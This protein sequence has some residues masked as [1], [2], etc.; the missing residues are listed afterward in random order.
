[1]DV[2]FWI[3]PAGSGK[4]HRCLVALRRAEREGRG[5]LF[6][7]PE[8]FTYSADR[9]LLDP[10]VGGPERL[11]E[12]AQAAAPA[13]HPETRSPAPAPEGTRHV[14][15]LSFRRL[16]YLV[17]DETGRFPPTVDPGG[18]EMLLRLAL[19]SVEE[20]GPLAPL[21][22]KEGF[23]RELA[24]LVRDLRLHAPDPDTPLGEKLASL[25]DPKLR[26]LGR[27]LR[28]YDTLLREAGLHDPEE[29]LD[30]A[31]RRLEASGA[32]VAGREVYVDGFMSFTAPEMRILRILARCARRLVVT[33]CL[34]PEDLRVFREA[35]DAAR[36][37]GIPCPEAGF[38][39]TVYRHLRRP[40]FS[41]TARTL[42]LLERAFSR[43]GLRVRIE[44]LRERPRFAHGVLARVEREVGSADA[45]TPP[46]KKADGA[47]ELAAAVNPAEEVLLW[48]RRIDRWV[49]LGQGMRYRDVAILLR[50]P[51]AYAGL[52]HEIFPRYDIPF[53]LDLPTDLSSHPLPATLLAILGIL[54]HAWSRDS[55]MAFLRSPLLGLSSFEADLVENVSL[56]YGIEY[57]RWYAAPWAACIVPPQRRTQE[58]EDEEEDGRLERELRI[59]EAQVAL[60]NRVRESYLLP[61]RR[62][63]ETWRDG[64]L[65]FREAVRGL[66]E[67]AEELNLREEAL[68]LAAAAEAAS[69]GSDPRSP[70]PAATFPDLRTTRQVFNHL[71]AFLEEGVRLMGNVPVT[72]LLFSR[73]LRDG[74]GALRLGRTPQSLDAVTIGDFQRSRINEARAVIV[75]GLTAEAV[76]RLVPDRPLLAREEEERM[77]RVGLLAGPS[78]QARQDEEAYLAYIALTRARERLLLTYPGN[79]TT[80]DALHVS[81]YLALL[82]ARLGRTIPVP[83][84]VETD[85]PQTPVELAASVGS[86]L[87]QQME[88]EEAGLAPVS[89]V[90]APGAAEGP[91]AEEGSGSEAGLMPES[92]TPAGPGTKEKTSPATLDHTAAMAL[93]AVGRRE[94]FPPP[95]AETLRRVLVHTRPWR[96]SPEVVRIVYPDGEVRTSATGLE[97]FSECPYRRFA[98]RVLRL[99]PRPDT[100]IRPRET[101]SAMH[102]A[103]ELFFRRR[104]LP[105]AEEID[106]LLEEIFSELLREP[107]FQ[108]FDLDAPSRYEWESLRRRLAHFLQAEARRLAEAAFRPERMESRFG[109]PGPEA[110]EALVVELGRRGRIVLRGAV[111]RVDAH[112]GNAVVV[113]Y[114]RTPRHGTVR[115]LLEEGRFLQ[116]G[117]YML[118]IRDLLGLQ[119]VGGFYVAVMPKPPQESESR[120][121]ENPLNIRFQGIILREELERYDPRGAFVTKGSSLVSEEELRRLLE[122]TRGYVRLFG[123]A[124]LEGQIRAVP[125]AGES[126]E[127]R[128]C[129][130]CDFRDLCRFDPLK[131]PVLTAHPD[132]L[133][134]EAGAGGTDP[135]EPGATADPA[136][137]NEPQPSAGRPDPEETPDA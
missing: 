10:A 85:P 92:D 45:A 27:I 53:F 13:S 22:G 59:Q 83:R 104:T 127:P 106:P 118:A 134:R 112:G 29:R 95:V 65:P 57:Q 46:A 93:Y 38:P 39:P 56:E 119:P 1:M 14:R 78:P 105:K 126:G 66:L 70:G 103:L 110:A 19:E 43:E 51:Q 5:A 23:V 111:D 72:P 122:R 60:G 86:R 117:I 8:Q 120:S 37:A 73:L 81:P 75:G 108:A 90:P 109:L 33:L 25:E 4:T 91:G 64:A 55:V 97:A 21:R 47:L 133:E 41:P 16:A 9:L 123:E 52:V 116:T 98:G 136:D 40:V 26:A 24:A 99:E 89:G 35:A 42:L 79:T 3:G 2:L 36:D 132:P 62:Y 11:G 129:G 34:D 76:P 115:R 113:D 30:V 100:V 131:A 94:L 71:A 67:L 88:R 135:E 31:A 137:P 49:R 107:E 80:G 32:L 124:I 77:A 15:V 84:P 69:S 50:D 17:E 20:L 101:G 44:E 125:L 114:K 6:L 61:V 58:E 121:E 18:R 87:V 74:L 28:A 102:R 48:A 7:V 82:A 128:A 68:R 130:Y 63:E 54:E 96:L 12:K